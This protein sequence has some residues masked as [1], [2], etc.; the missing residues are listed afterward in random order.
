MNQKQSLF[1][2]WWRL[3]NKLDIIEFILILLVFTIILIISGGAFSILEYVF[4]LLWLIIAELFFVFYFRK[5]IKKLTFNLHE[6]Q[7]EEDKITNKEI[8]I[9]QSLKLRKNISIYLIIFGICSFVILLLGILNL[10]E[11]YKNQFFRPILIILHVLILIPLIYSYF[12]KKNIKN[13][14]HIIMMFI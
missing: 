11:L 13:L 10:N 14:M 12:L 7:K 1:Y 2:R 5:R 4:M 3:E 6:I 8:M 9:T